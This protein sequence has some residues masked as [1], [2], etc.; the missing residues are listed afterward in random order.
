LGGDALLSDGSL[1]RT[2]GFAQRRRAAEGANLPL[3]SWGSVTAQVSE[4]A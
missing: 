4:P 3:G 1:A 2:T